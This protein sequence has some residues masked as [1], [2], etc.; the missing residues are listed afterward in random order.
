MVSKVVCTSSEGAIKYFE[1]H[2]NVADY[3]MEE[4]E[5]V[6]LGQFIGRVAE[7]LR[8]HEAAITREKFVA[9]AQCD[10]MGLGA[11]SKRQRA[12]EI[13]YIEFTYSPPKGVSV[14]AA[15]DERVKV[16]LYE[17]VKEELRWFETQVTVRDRRGHLANEEMTKPT[18]QM[19]AALFQHETSRTND[20]DFHVHALIGNMTWDE[21]RKGYFAIHYGQMLEL[22]KTLDA[23]M[24]NN[25]AARMGNLG[26]H[27][28]TAASGFGLREVPIPALA[29]FSE[30]TKQVETVLALLKRGY[31]AQQFKAVLKGVG[32]DEKRRMLAQGVENLR[33][34]LGAP[35][36]RP[37]L[38]ADYLIHEQ[39]VMLTRPKKVPITSKTLRE[40]V[41]KR[42][43]HAGLVVGKPSS[44]PVKAS[45]DLTQAIQQGTQLAFE[46]QSVVRLDKLLGEIVRLAPGEIANGR[47]AEYLRDDRRF[48]IRRRDGNEVVTTRQILGEEKT[49]LTSVI[50]GMGQREPLQK[51]YLPPV[52]LIATPRHIDKVVAQARLRGEELTPAQAEKW[53]N[54][55][56]AIHRY[57]C[58]SK[59][60]FLNIR[61]GAGVGK[62]FCM[63][64]LVGQSHRAGRS[65]FLC[66][67]YGEQARVTLRNEAPRLEALGRKEIARVFA[68]ANTVD[69]LLIQA[70]RDPTPFRG[71]DIYVDEAGLLDTP[72]A[73]PLVREAER[74]GARVIFQGDTEQMAA[75]GRGQPVK[76]LQDEL[77]LGM[78]VPRAS[79]SRRQLTVADKQLA[80][81]LSSGNEEK[82]AGAVAKMVERGMIRETPPDTAV[83][84]VAKEI[85]EAR[86]ANKDVVAV[87]SVHRISDALAERIHDLHVERAGREGQALFDVHV[88]R[89]LQP[90]EVRSS[91]FYRPGDVVEYKQDA[92]V[93]RASVTSVLPDGLVIE[94]LEKRLPLGQV[95]AVFDRSRIERGP[96]ERLLL[97]EKIKQDDRVFEK[98]SR[99]TIAR[100]IGDTVH[101]E[102]GLRLRASDGR[103]RQGD[104][105]TDYKAQGIKGAQVRGIE[106]N[107]SA[108]AMANKEAFHVKGTRHVQNL[109]LHV[110]NKELYVEAIQRSNVKFSALQLE[111][112]PIAAAVIPLLAVDK[113]RLLMKMRSWGK[114]F[115]TRVAG[116]KAAEQVRHLTRLESLRPQVKKVVTEKEVVAEKVTPAIK[117]AVT[118]KVTPAP[119]PAREKFR[120]GLSTPVEEMTQKLRQ[121][122][123]EPLQQRPAPPSVR[124]KQS[125]FHVRPAPR[126]RQGR[127]IRM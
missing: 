80:A 56:A 92:A 89:D 13:K 61:G 60:Q 21:E 79:I 16:E 103:V 39:A 94:N 36:G 74:V 105:L 43:N 19:I 85:V 126:H 38:R 22:R 9:F 3:F 118:E 18:G 90:A 68:Q 95:R 87:S 71:A 120:E 6:D 76:L 30:R 116:Q 119:Q 55:F 100:V 113:N 101:F 41:A 49:L 14:V 114:E 91:Q 84:T 34:R 77:G 8:L 45:M 107:G 73:L 50:N 20:P 104:C 2:L 53:L 28:E 40:D 67:P 108:L 54:Q 58:T 82:F 24:H 5:K 112:M 124:P 102:S 57:V 117:E 15:L 29:L 70:R 69:A 31:T 125:P 59:D 64:E 115:L 110:E 48:L 42:L 32:E 62:T 111:R 65:I 83:E 47:L 25:L 109:I 33:E 78:H 99:Q 37:S 72:K 86:A 66:A 11:D 106:D 46:K 75:V 44:F 127:G 98:G 7:R 27:V 96:G 63:E 12:S 122:H 17:A 35:Q 4:G 121:K 10:T 81:D 26:Y 93:V 23:R 52:E 88:K 1:A 51:D 97:Q 123:D